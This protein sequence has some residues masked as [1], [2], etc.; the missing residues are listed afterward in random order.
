MHFIPLLCF[1]TYFPITMHILTNVCN[2]S[3]LNLLIFVNPLLHTPFSP[4][5]LYPPRLSKQKAGMNKYRFEFVTSLKHAVSF[6]S[7]AG[8][9][10]LSHYTQ[11]NIIYDS[12]SYFFTARSSGGNYKSSKR[13]NSRKQ[14]CNRPPDHEFRQ[15][16]T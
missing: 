13:H 7:K 11:A 8:Q 1:T 2:F 5:W 14:L 6:L 10:I 3:N 12:T 4:H 16:D 9:G 15:L